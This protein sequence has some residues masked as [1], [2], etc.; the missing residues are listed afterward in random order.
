MLLTHKAVDS[1]RGEDLRTA[2]LVRWEEDYT[3]AG[4]RKRLVRIFA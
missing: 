2:Q 3:P 1:T 4:N